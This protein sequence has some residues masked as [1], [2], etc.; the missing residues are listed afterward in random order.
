MSVQALRIGKDPHRAFLRTTPN[1]HASARSAMEKWLAGSLWGN[2]IQVGPDR[3]HV[4]G[5]W[6]RDW[7][8]VYVEFNA[9]SIIVTRPLR[10]LVVGG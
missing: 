6:L 3:F 8:V 7:S 10:S 1:R 2:P 4:Y 5:L 9:Q